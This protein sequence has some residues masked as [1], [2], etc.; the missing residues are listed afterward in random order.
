MSQHMV[1]VQIDVAAENGDVSVRRHHQS[2][3]G[4]LSVTGVAE[5]IGEA[6]SVLRAELGSAAVDDVV[7]FFRRGYTGGQA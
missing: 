4:K 1:N 3:D 7:Y 5:S 6:L 2:N